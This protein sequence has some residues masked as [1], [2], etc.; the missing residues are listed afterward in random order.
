M[1]VYAC[2]HQ[3]AIS[4]CSYC[5]H[6][7]TGARKPPQHPQNTSSWPSTRG[8]PLRAP[9]GM[10]PTTFW[11]HPNPPLRPDFSIFP[12]RI[13]VGTCLA[14]AIESARMLW[15][16]QNF[17][18]SPSRQHSTGPACVCWNQIFIFAWRV[19]QRRPPPTLLWLGPSCNRRR[20][21]QDRPGRLKLGSL[22]LPPALCKTHPRALKSDAYFGCSGAP[23]L[24]PLT[25][26][27]CAAISSRM[28]SMC[29]K[30]AQFVRN[31][32]LLNL[33][34]GSGRTAHWL[35]R[36]GRFKLGVSGMCM[37]V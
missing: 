25:N 21:G 15:T 3:Y 33:F 11:P 29:P 27:C 5:M 36:Y 8:D 16:R 9:Q 28:R 19:H 37:Y 2:M 4:I 14:T 20:I 12:S 23:K 35:P 17:A 6:W 31:G 13:G 26:V 7:T 18:E 1:H 32:R 30:P 34:F 24:T 22:V 10:C